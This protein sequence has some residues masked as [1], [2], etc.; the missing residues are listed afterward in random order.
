MP[1]DTA[2]RGRLL[3]ATPGLREPT[4]HR[5]VILLLDHGEGGAVGVVLNRPSTVDV[6]VVLPEWHAHVSDPPLLFHGGPVGLDTAMGVVTIP[7]GAD[8]SP[9]VDRMAGR[10]G[11]VDL[12]AAPESVAPHVGGV[13]VFAGYAGWGEGQLEDE[14]AERSWFVV[15][16]IADDVLTAD[17]TRLWRRVLRRQGGDLAIVSTFAEDASLN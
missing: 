10:F 1:D 14:L 4:F 15:D 16:A 8:L 7:H 6:S 17:P 3:V 9:E 5:T 2:L 12:D 11:L 13:R